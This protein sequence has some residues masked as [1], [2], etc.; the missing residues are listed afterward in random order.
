MSIP[1]TCQKIQDQITAL[2]KQV[3]EITSGPDFIQDHTGPHPGKPDPEL[4]AE[5]KKLE[6]QLTSKHAAFETCLLNN[7]PPFPVKIAVT[8]IH[9][10][11]GTSE[12]GSDEPYVIVTAVDLSSLVP[13]LE[14][15]LYGPLSMNAGESK[16]TGGPPFWSINNKTGKTISDP[17]QVIFIVAMME[18]DDGSPSAARVIIKGAAVASLTASINQPRATRVQKLLA[19]IDSAMGIPTGG[20]NFDDGIG[21]PLELKLS[22]LDLI[23]PILG[24]QSASMTFT[25]DGQFAVNFLITKA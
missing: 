19:D 16:P 20:P 12:I 5:A 14:S 7:V 21:K 17:S 3:F 4:L 22:K 18:N 8:S 23:L 13:S 15:T 24:P 10:I 2:E 1:A 6:A 11:K 9:S 25:G